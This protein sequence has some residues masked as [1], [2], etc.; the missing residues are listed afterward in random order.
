MAIPDL[1]PIAMGTLAA[2]ALVFSANADDGVVLCPF[3]RCTGGYCPGCGATRAANRLV[4]GDLRASWSH[5][6]WVVLVAAQIVAA[7]FVLAFIPATRRVGLRRA[8][9]PLMAVNAVLV[10]AIWIAR[11]ST[12]SI[13]TGWM[14]AI[15]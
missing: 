9:I 14:S 2:G 11:L 5:H 10:I 8:A 1:A 6:P 3:R 15:F 12:G 13:P 7:A 4:R